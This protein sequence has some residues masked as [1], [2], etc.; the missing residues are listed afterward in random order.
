MVEFLE[1]MVEF[2]SKF[3]CHGIKIYRVNSIRVA[4]SVIFFNILWAI[5][6]WVT[7]SSAIVFFALSLRLLPLVSIL[8]LCVLVL[9]LWC[10]SDG[11]HSL[12]YWVSLSTVLHHTPCTHTLAYAARTHTLAPHA[13]SRFQAQSLA[14]H[15]HT[16]LRH[17]HACS[18]IT[19]DKIS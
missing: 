15:A 12:N 6:P 8:W 19:T 7:S 1:W 18:L 10:S 5:A 4:K 14:P 16:R 9:S 17:I 2:L 3:Q 11:G 13:H